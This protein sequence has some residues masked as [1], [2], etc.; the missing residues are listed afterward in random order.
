MRVKALCCRSFRESVRR[1]AGVWPV[2]SP[3]VC[4][5]TFDPGYLECE[6]LYLKLHGLEGQPYWYGDGWATACSASQ[7]RLANLRG[8][9]VF[10]GNCY[11]PESPMLQALFDAGAR[12]VVCGSGENYGARG[13]V[14]GADVLGR[15]FVQ[16][17]QLAAVPWPWL[18]LRVAKL[19]IGATLRRDR[20]LRDT[21]AFE[22]WTPEGKREDVCG[23]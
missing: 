20:V 23:D 22:L 6:L 21:L 2:T 18:A 4:M 19:R 8:T 3:P 14:R 12:A 1:A 10:A 5:E 7:V 9:V 16:A 17:M 13:V 15:A 11:L